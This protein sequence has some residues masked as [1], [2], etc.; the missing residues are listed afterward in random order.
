MKIRIEDIP[1]SGTEVNADSAQAEWLKLLLTD[2]LG[3]ERIGEDDVARLNLQLFKHEKDVTLIGGIILKFHPSCDRCLTIFQK[4]QQVPMHMILMPAS[5]AEGKKDDNPTDDEEV[6]FYKGNEIDLSEIVKEQIIL[7]QQMV[8]ICKDD[9]K[10]LCPKCGKNLNN[11]ACKC[12]NTDK[13]KSPFAVL[14]KIPA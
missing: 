11:G 12:K 13:K 6:S 7:A 10:G 4:Q 1:D 5:V 14:K 8:N 9:C 3:P 2:V